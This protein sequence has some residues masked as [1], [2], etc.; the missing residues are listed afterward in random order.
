MSDEIGQWIIYAEQDWLYALNGLEKFPRPAT[1]SLQQAAEKYLK[2][3]LLHLGKEPPRGHDLL[4]LLTLTGILLPDDVRDAA[5][6]LNV[7]GPTRRY[8]GDLP[9]IT[10]E[11]AI[12]AKVA[13]NVLRLWVRGQLELEG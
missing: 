3:L 6:E 2:A 1:W 9:E 10:S 7:Y 5:A 12:S 11:E 4:F 8:P 13:T